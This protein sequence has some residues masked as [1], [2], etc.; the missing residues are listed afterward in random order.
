M[1][2]NTFILKIYNVSFRLIGEENKASDIATLAVDRVLT[3]FNCQETITDKMLKICSMEVCYIFL[4]ESNTICNIKDFTSQI[5]N[6]IENLVQAS[7]LMLEPLN[8]V[9]IVWK[10]ILG[11]ELIELNDIVKLQKK[12]LNY[13]LFNSRK[14]LKDQ[15]SKLKISQK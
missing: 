3:K 8:R 5:D 7:I 6:K 12:E 4:T 13:L 1:N 10:D 9:V 11:Y 14:H 2:F 15:L